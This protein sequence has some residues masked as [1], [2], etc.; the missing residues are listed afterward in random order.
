MP[1]NFTTNTGDIMESFGA[2]YV[3]ISGGDNNIKL[4]TDF[5][6]I[7]MTISPSYKD[8]ASLFYFEEGKWTELYKIPKMSIV[9]N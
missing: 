2:I 9:N 5:M 7:V 4:G 1:G 3:S 6:K 8:E